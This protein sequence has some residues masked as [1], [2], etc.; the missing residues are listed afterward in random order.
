MHK[1]NVAVP[2]NEQKMNGVL[3]RPD[4]VENFAAV[5]FLHGMTSRLD[6]YV[7]IAEALAAQNIVALA[8]SMRGHGKSD[9]DFNELT[10]NDLVDDGIAAYDFL[11]SLPFVNKNRIGVVG[12]SVGANVAA[13]VSQLCAVRALILRVP[14]LY[15]REN[16][17]LTLAET[18]K[19]ESGLFKG[20]KNMDET[21][22]IQAIR[23]FSESL[24]VIPSEK[25]P[26]IPPE[27]PQR[28][29][30]A[31]VKAKKRHLV[32]IKG[33]PHALNEPEWK[34]QFVELVVNWM[35]SEL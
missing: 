32:E 20:I 11:A 12:A 7:P 17:A 22:S 26:I 31:A 13:L 35:V 27:V 15:T 21:P 28:Y 2:V 18:M 3:I 30:D 10:V 19:R 1:E 25:D 4:G 16:M 23:Q 5:F 6:G 33:A 24:L 9:G 34:Q 8:L 14:A 29:Y